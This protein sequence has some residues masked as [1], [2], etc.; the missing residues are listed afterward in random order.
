MISKGPF[1]AK[2]SCVSV[3]LLKVSNT[4]GYIIPTDIQHRHPL[5]INST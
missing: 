5:A 3:I 1:Q 2:Q 4:I